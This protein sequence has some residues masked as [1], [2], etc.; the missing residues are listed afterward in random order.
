MGRA[1]QVIGRGLKC[2]SHWLRNG[3]GCQWP[4]EARRRQARK[5]SPI[6]GPHQHLSFRL[7][8][9]S[10]MR[11][12]ISVVSKPPVCV[13]C[14]RCPTEL[15]HINNT[16]MKIRKC[17]NNTLL[18]YHNFINSHS[19]FFQGPFFLQAKLYPRI[20]HWVLLSSLLR[21]HW[22]IWICSSTFP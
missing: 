3:K 2:H 21:F 17:N 16:F 6:Q 15:I 12:C 8:G 14:H 11:Q 18:E 19:N 13:F 20:T 4:P 9:P 10:A 7:W 22:S 1:T 5:G